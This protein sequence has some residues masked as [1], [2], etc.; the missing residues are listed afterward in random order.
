MSVDRGHRPGGGWSS[1][2]QTWGAAGCMPLLPLLQP[3]PDAFKFEKAHQ[4]SASSPWRLPVGHGD[5]V[6]LCCTQCSLSLDSQRHSERG[7]RDCSAGSGHPPPLE[8]HC[9]LYREQACGCPSRTGLGKARAKGQ[10]CISRPGSRPPAGR[11]L[12]S[13]GS[14]AR[15]GVT[16]WGHT[17]TTQPRPCSATVICTAH[18]PAGTTAARGAP[19]PSGSKAPGTYSTR[20]V[21]LAGPVGHGTPGNRQ[22]ACPLRRPQRLVEGASYA[23]N[24]RHENPVA[25][26]QLGGD[27]KRA[28]EGCL[29]GPCNTVHMD[30]WAGWA[31]SRLRSWPPDGWL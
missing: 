12:W 20:E 6:L 18:H 15:G 17:V 22:L 30:G 10:E 4:E 27:V 3:S 2:H 28:E 31:V 16:D 29:A 23:G 24:S 9:R 11:P 1:A 21:A 19:S 8:W 13:G 7:E 14:I 26:V 25:S 5:N